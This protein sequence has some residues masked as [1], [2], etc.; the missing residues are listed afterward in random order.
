MP[1]NAGEA[2]SARTRD[3]WILAA[4]D[5]PGPSRNRAIRFSDRPFQLVPRRGLEPP[6]DFTPTSTSSWRV[7]QFRHLGLA[8]LRKSILAPRAMSRDPNRILFCP[9]RPIAYLEYS[10]VTKTSRET[11]EPC[12]RS[13]RRALSTSNRCSH[14]HTQTKDQHLLDR[15]RIGGI[16]DT[17]ER[18]LICGRP[19]LPTPMLGTNP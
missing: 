7:C 18:A 19:G 13:L 2:A 11:G 10:S 9:L 4:I 6:R 5:Y 3:P 15:P 17:E 16:L 1:A 14:D 12:G 8:L